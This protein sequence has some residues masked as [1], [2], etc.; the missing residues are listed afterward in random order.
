M[1]LRLPEWGKHSAGGEWVWYVMVW[2]L[3]IAQ[4]ENTG[5]LTSYR[6][7]VGF[8]KNKIILLTHMTFY[9]FS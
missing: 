7:A 4:L 1:G 5:L 8:S 2:V 3:G 9:T 6:L